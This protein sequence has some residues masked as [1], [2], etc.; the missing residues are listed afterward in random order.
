MALGSELVGQRAEDERDHRQRRQQA[1]RQPRSAPHRRER[2]HRRLEG[3]RAGASRG[4]WRAR[5]PC[6]LAARAASVA[7]WRCAA[8]SRTPA[9]SA[10]SNARASRTACAADSRMERGS[11]AWRD[12]RACGRRGWGSGSPSD[13]T[14][15][16]AKM[17]ETR[18][19][20]LG[21]V[22]CPSRCS[23]R[24]RDL[25]WDAF[26]ADQLTGEDA[27]SCRPASSPSIAVRTASSASVPRRAV[28]PAIGCAAPRATPPRCRRSATGAGAAAVERRRPDD[29][30]PRARPALGVHAKGRRA[31]HG[32]GRRRQRRRGV[33]VVTSLNRDL[34][35]RRLGALP[36]AGL[37][38][39][40]RARGRAH[41]GRPVRRPGRATGGGRGDLPDLPVHAS[42]RR[43]GAPA[44]LTLRARRSEPV[45]PA[46]CWA[47]RGGQVDAGQRARRTRAAG[48]PRDDG[49]RPRRA[50]HYRAPAAL[51]RRR[52]HAHRHAGDARWASS[53]RC[54]ALDR[55]FADVAA[56]AAACRFTD[57]RHEEDPDCAV[58]AALADGTLPADRWES[59]V[60]LQGE[61]ATRRRA[62]I[63]SGT[64]RE[65][66]PE[67]AR[68]ASRHR[69]R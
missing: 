27:A 20:R 26:F 8:L 44:F 39:R 25:G 46:C 47:R 65:A 34:S 13:G 49:G 40:R 60:K 12:G 2:R 29:D 30:P 16:R 51:P 56:V 3:T 9:S 6:P 43:A 10:S 17:P 37:E 55:A 67:G 53:A 18:A 32:H 63:R 45:G 58:T 41:Q 59:Y 42:C 22:L 66:A 15:A 31:G 28:V 62:R 54:D 57:C 33:F 35:P 61:L 50:H 7:S 4:S 48:G 69:R 23:A 64:W 24:S 11:D 5:R 52:R 1:E 38:Q 14:R 19:G 21:A 68:A 36:D